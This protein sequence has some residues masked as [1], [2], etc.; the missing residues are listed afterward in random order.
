MGVARLRVMPRLR[1]HA[2]IFGMGALLLLIGC[3]MKND[4]PE[5]AQCVDREGHVV[6]ERFCADA[7][8]GGGANDF[9]LYYMLFGGFNRYPVGYLI[10]QETRSTL[11]SE[12]RA[13]ATYHTTSGAARTFTDARTSA[14]AP[15]VAPKPPAGPQG[16]IRQPN[17]GS[18]KPPSS[19]GSSKPPGAGGPPKPPSGGGGSSKPPSGGGGGGVRSGGGGRR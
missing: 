10:P 17:G 16:D 11:S 9:L 6:E 1:H 14:P 5:V 19:G 8:G 4:G 12:P 2:A 3:G 18:A 13:G 7:H 15:N